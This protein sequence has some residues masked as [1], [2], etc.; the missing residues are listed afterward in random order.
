MSSTVDPVSFESIAPQPVRTL[1]GSRMI[2]RG[3][4]GMVGVALI[5]TALG[6]WVAPGAS[7]DHELMLFKLLAS[8]VGGMMG[9]ALLQGFARP[10]PP[11]VEVDTIR[12]EVRLVRTRGKDRFVLDRCSFKNL[13]RVEN[14]GTYVKLWG[15]NDALLAEVAASDRVAHRSL[16]TALR[17]AGKL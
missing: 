14:S 16:V 10:A 8:A 6:L 1:D 7:W 15:K 9:I 4:Q 12:H 11:K 2:M 5:L 13:T 3:V 17:V